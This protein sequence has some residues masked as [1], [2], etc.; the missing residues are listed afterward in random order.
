[1]YSNCNII[2]SKRVVLMA[3]ETHLISALLQKNGDVK[4]VSIDRSTKFKVNDVFEIE[5]EV[6]VIQS[7]FER[8]IF[9]GDLVQLDGQDSIKSNMVG[10]QR[11]SEESRP[12]KSEYK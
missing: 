6:I 2:E 8:K 9:Y 12:I 7:F 4:E 11:H 10:A 1:M 5:S 3:R